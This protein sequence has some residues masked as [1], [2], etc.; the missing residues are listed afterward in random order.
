M[1]Q[2]AQPISE[3]RP[4]AGYA[5]S[6]GVLGLIVS[7][8]IAVALRAEQGARISPSDWAAIRF[9]VLQ[10]ALSALIS[11]GLAIPAA[12]ALA[13]RDFPLKGLAI[14]LLGAP[15]LLPVLVAAMGL[16]AVFG[17]SG[18]LSEMLALI[19]LPPVQIYGFHGVVLAH[20]FF[21]LPLATRIILQGWL[22]IPSE[23]FRLARA[24]NFSPQDTA[25]HLE[26]PMLLSVVPGA[27]LVIFLICTTSFAVA[28][29]LGGGPKATTIELAIYQAF[30]FDFDLAKAA[31]LGGIQVAICVVAVLLAR[32][33]PVPDGMGAGLDRKVGITAPSS[34]W[35]LAQDIAV[36]ALVILFLLTPLGMI[37][38]GGIKG[39][40]VMP[41]E[42]W[43]AAARSIFVAL[44]SV[45][46]TF[47]L[48]LPLAFALAGHSRLADLATSVPVALSPLVLGLGLFI[49]LFPY[50]DPRAAALPVTALVNAL[51]SLPFVTRILAPPVRALRQDYGRLSASL[52]VTGIAW[53]RLVAVPRLRRPLGF[54]AGLAAAL[55]MGDLGVVVLFADNDSATLPLMLYR[56]L[57]AYRVE[58]AGGAALLLLI[59][60]LVLFWC[61][62][63]GGRAHAAL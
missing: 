19:G 26:R 14:T 21:N 40:A 60:S 39:L 62:D 46:V 56:L 11:V 1:A 63:R 6:L 51:M 53:A 12:R 4:L 7:T 13:R 16:I 35:L 34:R 52:G 58:E 15:F 45:V 61:F 20:V 25:R 47:T 59:L 3:K 31:M 44:G 32:G 2:R 10:A 17:R 30:R 27:L 28:L 55:S 43:W 42:V 23:R 5:V 29:V 57:A 33:F 24:L 18:L 36:I 48:A 8:G 49:M 50:V 37:V 9:T 54:G 38:L 22:A 41:P